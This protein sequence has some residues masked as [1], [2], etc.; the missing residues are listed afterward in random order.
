MQRRPCAR[1][2]K[3]LPTFLVFLGAAGLLIITANSGLDSY[4]KEGADQQMLLSHTAYWTG[5]FNIYGP[6]V[7]CRIDG[8]Q[9]WIEYAYGDHAVD[10]HYIRYAK[11]DDAWRGIYWKWEGC[12]DWS[13]DAQQ[14]YELGWY[15]DSDPP[16]GECGNQRNDYV[17]YRYRESY[18]SVNHVARQYHQVGGGSTQC[19]RRIGLSNNGRWKTL[20]E[21]STSYCSG[22]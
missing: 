7:E 14:I 20:E 3:R 10:R 4:A 18:P 22:D 16:V 17:D 12:E 21:T 13:T 9:H 5:W 15:G 19:E 6:Q 11:A 8:Q 2:R 1:F